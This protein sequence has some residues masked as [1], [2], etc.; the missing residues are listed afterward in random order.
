[1]V[2]TESKFSGGKKAQNAVVEV[3]DARGHKLLAG[4]T[5]ENGAFSF[6]APQ[7]GELKIVLIAG[8]G[9]R[10][11]WTVSADEF[12]NIMAVDSEPVQKLPAT[13]NAVKAELTPEKKYVMETGLTPED[14]QAIVE[15]ALDKKLA[16]VLTKLNKPEDPRHGPGFSEIFGGIGYILG[17]MG[18]ATYVN[19]RKKK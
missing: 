2:Y 17:L 10:G 11:E 4:K 16:P 1:M 13:E 5:D 7:K 8:M 18:L 3:F 19:F 14:I 9:H 15:K 6:K 12:E